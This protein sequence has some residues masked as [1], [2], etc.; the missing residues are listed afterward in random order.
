[1]K[2]LPMQILVKKK[3]FT[4]VSNTP[5]SMRENFIQAINSAHNWSWYFT[6]NDLTALSYDKNN[7]SCVPFEYK[8]FAIS[9]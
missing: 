8:L 5:N 1:M 4:H 9:L 7:N 3:K 6:L 2:T